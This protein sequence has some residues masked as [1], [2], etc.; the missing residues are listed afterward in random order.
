MIELWETYSSIIADNEEVCQ[1]VKKEPLT[2]SASL[3][4]VSDMFQSDVK[5]DQK[6][7]LL[8]TEDIIIKLLYFIEFWKQNRAQK[9]N[10]IFVLKILTKILDDAQDDP[11]EL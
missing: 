5:S 9:K 1:A 4:N 10:V 11:E 2:F 3:W 8:N 7:L 6:D